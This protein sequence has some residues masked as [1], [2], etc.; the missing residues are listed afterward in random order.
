VCADAVAAML[1]H[2]QPVGADIS[3]LHMAPSDRAS[4]HLL[5]TEQA[6]AEQAHLAAADRLLPGASQP[7]PPVTNC[8]CAVSTAKA[9]I[10]SVWYPAMDRTGISCLCKHTHRGSEHSRN[11]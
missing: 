6:A 8:W 4:F 1:L 7:T 9:K 5:A 11:L 10:G 3:A 2:A